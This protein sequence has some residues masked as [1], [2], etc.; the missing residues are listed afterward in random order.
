MQ[1]DKKQTK[2]KILLNLFL[3]NILYFASIFAEQQLLRKGYP[4]FQ[5]PFDMNI[6]EF[7]ALLIPGSIIVTGISLMLIKRAWIF[8]AVIISVLILSSIFFNYRLFQ[9]YSTPFT[10]TRPG[11]L[12]TLG[13]NYWQ[14]DYPYAVLSTIYEKYYLHRV[15][16]NPEIDNLD[17][18]SRVI[19]F[20]V[21]LI[22]SRGVP[23]SIN[24]DQFSR[25]EETMGDNFLQISQ[26]D[27]VYRL[28]D[29]KSGEDLLITLA[30]NMILFLP[31]DLLTD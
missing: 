30:D 10:T 22:E 1:Q 9:F 26:N 2:E 8:R 28:Y 23:V 11:D 31:R 3:F 27:K 13:E 24:G 17:E 25:L 18:L 6:M 15:F 5:L 29:V 21:N 20:G 4:S 14:H 16:I 7:F 19:R 12:E